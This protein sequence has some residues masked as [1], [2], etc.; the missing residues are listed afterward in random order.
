MGGGHTADPDS[1]PQESGT[2]GR[3]AWTRPGRVAT[4][5]TVAVTR[6][7]GREAPLGLWDDLANPATD[8]SRRRL[9][10]QV[11]ADR[12]IQVTHKINICVWIR[13]LTGWFA[14]SAVWILLASE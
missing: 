13:G 5:H 3:G 1:A 6:F 7:I 2:G 9:D 10:G 4:T 12:G 14:S 11:M 8:V